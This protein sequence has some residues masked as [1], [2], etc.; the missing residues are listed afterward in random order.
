MI[1]ALVL[2]GLV[3]VAE[4]EE[5]D[6]GIQSSLLLGV[7]IQTG[8]RDV[9]VIA[10]LHLLVELLEAMPMRPPQ[11]QPDADVGMQPAEQPLVGL[12]LEH[13]L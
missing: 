13:L 1:T 4:D 5:I 8:L 7:L 2:H 11:G 6:G 3:L 12:E 9:V 10:A